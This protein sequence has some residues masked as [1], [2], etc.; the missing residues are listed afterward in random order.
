MPRLAPVINIFFIDG[1]LKYLFSLESPAKPFTRTLEIQPS[2][3]LY[4]RTAT[5][6]MKL[7]EIP[8]EIK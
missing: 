8:L 7:Y 5:Q 4:Y 2:A 3:L 1:F 6:P